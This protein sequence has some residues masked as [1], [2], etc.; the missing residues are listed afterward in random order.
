MEQIYNTILP[1]ALSIGV[2]YDLFWTLNPK[3]LQP[4]DKAFFIRQQQNDTMAWLIGRYVQDAIGSAMN[5]KHKYPSEPYMSKSDVESAKRKQDD[6]MSQEEIKR[7]VMAH[8]ALIN[9]DKKKK[10]GG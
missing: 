1:N 8:V 10:K 5:P 7:R 9:A 6:R 4:F 2:D 3:S